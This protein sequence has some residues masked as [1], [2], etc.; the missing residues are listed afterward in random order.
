MTSP[1]TPK[2]ES[3]TTMAKLADAGKITVG[4]KFDQPGFG[5]L[6]SRTSRRA[7]TSRSRRSSPARWE[8][9][10]D[11]ITWKETPSDVREQLIED[12]EVDLVAG[13]LHDQ[14]RAQAA[15]HLRRP[16]LRGRPEADGEGGRRRHHRPGPEGQPGREGLLGDRLDPVGEHQALPGQ[17]R[18]LVLFD[19]YDKCADALQQRPGRGRDH[20]QRRSCSASSSKSDGDFKLVGE[21]FT[22]EPYGIGIKK[23]DVEFCKFINDTLK[24]A[25][26]TP[27][28]RRGRTPPARSRARRPR[29][30]RAQ[31]PAA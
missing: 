5:L 8:S 1:R 7:S 14:R 4:T 26:R 19:V 23:G 21:Q 6:T 20:G 16:V 28:R 24:E 2:F 3:G 13:D 29:P 25:T 30:C 12:G 15:D 27:T 22:E 11:D 17:A 31:R 18:Q 10:T 9:A